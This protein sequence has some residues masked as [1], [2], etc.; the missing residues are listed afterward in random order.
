MFAIKMCVCRPV[1]LSRSH[2]LIGRIISFVYGYMRVLRCA[3]PVVRLNYM[4]R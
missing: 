3:I 1:L 2:D 4:V